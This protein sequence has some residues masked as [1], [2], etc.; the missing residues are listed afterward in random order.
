MTR[1]IDLPMVKICWRC[2]GDGMKTRLTEYGYIQSICDVCHGAKNLGKLD[3]LEL[4][5][6]EDERSES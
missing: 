3:E 5:S 6:S 4:Q 1:E 2:D